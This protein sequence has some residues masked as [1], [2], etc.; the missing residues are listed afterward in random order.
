MYARSTTV[1]G[2]PEAVDDGIAYVRDRVMPAVEAAEGCVGLSMLADRES[3]RCIVATAWTDDQVMRSTAED[4]LPA[5][6]LVQALGG[7]KAQIQEWDVAVLHRAR[8]AGDAA[9]AQVTWARVTPNHVTELI[10]A[11][12]L[13]LLPRLQELPGYASLSMVVD[14]RNGR[15]VSV[16]SFES[17]EALARTRKHARHLREQFARAMAAKIVD[18]AEM[19]LVL[20]HLRV[21]ETL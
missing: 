10:D 5:D 7:E 16:T 15:T 14:R 17:P 6:R 8:P 11:F 12:R 9:R 19:D 3:G 2:N 21:P 1:L 13:N 20:A 18:V 4:L